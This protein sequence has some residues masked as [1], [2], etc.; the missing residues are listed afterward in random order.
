MKKEHLPRSG[1]FTAKHFVATLFILVGI[2]LLARNM[3]WISETLFDILVSWKMLLVTI[4]F[5]TMLRRHYF[6]GMILLL[7]GG[8]F[9][10]PEFNCLPV[11]VSM[12]IWPSLLII[13]G[14][15]FFMKRCSGRRFRS[16]GPNNEYTQYKSTDG[17]FRFENKFSGIHQ[18]ISDRIFRGASIRNFFGG[19]IIDLRHT[20]IEPGRT[21]IDID[22][23]FGG[24]QI[25]VPS[26]WKVD[27][28]VNAFIGGCEDKRIQKMETN[29]ELVLVIRGNL[30]FSG[31]EIKN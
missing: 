14:I 17:F 26:H 13:I 7:I 19:A 12:L 8:C 24:V 31:I 28:A 11:S 22:S 4:G 1:R 25:Y 6:S 10:L 5:Y 21:Y 23:K 16:S 30:S 9:L 20:H 3:Q 18:V 29:Q 2:L 15:S 27:V